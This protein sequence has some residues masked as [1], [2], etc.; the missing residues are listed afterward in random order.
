[1]AADVYSRPPHTGRGGWT[2]YTGAAGWMYRVGVE[3]LLGLTLQAGSLHVDPCLPQSWPGYEA[4]L[5]TARGEYQIVVENPDRVS[6]G[7]RSIEVDGQVQADPALPIPDADGKHHVR[8][9]LGT[10][11]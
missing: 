9:I 11:T 6:R 4:V 5:R 1:M 8:V 3:S 2:W 7:V 10:Q